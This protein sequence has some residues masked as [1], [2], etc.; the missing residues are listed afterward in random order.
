[1]QEQKSTVDKMNS[2]PVL[3]TCPSFSLFVSR[4]STADGQ[5]HLTRLFPQGPTRLQLS[6]PL[7]AAVSG[8]AVAGGLELAL[9]AD[10]RVVE[11][12][13]VMGVFC[14]RFGTFCRPVSKISHNKRGRILT[15]SSGC[16]HL[17]GVCLK[18]K[19]GVI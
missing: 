7:I 17:L 6:K 9:L 19:H 13:A 12:S 1:M 10:L 8:F 18:D 3:R 15:K 4:V 16:N 11:K 2:C 14:R 5:N